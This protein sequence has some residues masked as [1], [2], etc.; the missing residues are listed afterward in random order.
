MPMEWSKVTL[1][2]LSILTSTSNV[3]S[4][5]LTTRF[6]RSNSLRLWSVK[7][8]W[9]ML[10]STWRCC[11]FMNETC[12]NKSRDLIGS[13]QQ[14][15]YTA[16][17]SP[18]RPTLPVV[19]GGWSS[20]TTRTWLHQADSTYSRPR[21]KKWMSSC[22]RNNSGELCQLAQAYIR[23]I[24]LHRACWPFYQKCTRATGRVR[25]V[26][27]QLGGNQVLHRQTIFIVCVSEERCATYF[28][29]HETF[30]SKIKPKEN[31]KSPR[32]EL[33]CVKPRP[34]WPSVGTRSGGRPRARAGAVAAPSLPRTRPETKKSNSCLNKTGSLRAHHQKVMNLRPVYSS[35][36]FFFFSKTAKKSNS[37][38]HALRK[39]VY[40]PAQKPSRKNINWFERRQGQ[41]TLRFSKGRVTQPPFVTSQCVQLATAKQYR[42][43]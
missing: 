20:T 16:H 31:T 10:V 22:A 38:K 4:T 27:L 25:F 30:A 34:P 11:H 26:T 3:S 19:G 29:S 9:K 15:S 23:Q 37:C 41:P 14:R 6:Y 40:F 43:Q 36:F 28:P 1:Q 12:K 8:N 13:I 7:S 18:Q 21:P 33:H 39:K 42:V 17:Y 24:S 5:E 35:F 32:G 2:P